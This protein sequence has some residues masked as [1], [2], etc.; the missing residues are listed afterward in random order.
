MK[1]DLTRFIL[2]CLNRPIATILAPFAL[3]FVSFVV[4]PDL[5]RELFPTIENV[6]IKDVWY[7][8]ADTLRFRVTFRRNKSRWCPVQI[9]YRYVFADGAR[10]PLPFDGRV[11][12]VAP[13]GDVLKPVGGRAITCFRANEPGRELEVFYQFRLPEDPSPGDILKAWVSYQGPF[14]LGYVTTYPYGEIVVPPLPEVP[15]LEYRDRVIRQQLKDA[16]QM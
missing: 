13:N 16:Q 5:E 6:E 2:F 15:A 8:D 4:I 14:P 1:K 11:Y 10:R 12:R 3:I 9:E 7:V